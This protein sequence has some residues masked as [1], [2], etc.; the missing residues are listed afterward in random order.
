MAKNGKKVEFNE[1]ITKDEKNESTN[2]KASVASVT[3][4][5]SETLF[6]G[7]ASTEAA[8]VDA[9]DINDELDTTRASVAQWLTENVLR[10]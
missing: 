1:N 8:L 3:E 4:E 9:S 5:V 2:P 10:K 6:D 7:V